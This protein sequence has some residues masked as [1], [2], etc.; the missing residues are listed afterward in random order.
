MVSSSL[1]NSMNG[2]SSM[3]LEGEGGGAWACSSHYGR[4]EDFSRALNF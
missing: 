4:I 3:R 1:L 2:S